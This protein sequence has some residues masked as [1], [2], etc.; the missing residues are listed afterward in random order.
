M[1]RV[2]HGDLFR[3]LADAYADAA[4]RIAEADVAYVAGLT[5]REAIAECVVVGTLLGDKVIAAL[6]RIAQA[7]ATARRFETDGRA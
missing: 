4:E 7:D 1:A 6:R 3:E 5:D 2:G